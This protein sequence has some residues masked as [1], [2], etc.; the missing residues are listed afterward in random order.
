M[1][2]NFVASL[3]LLSHRFFRALHGGSQVL[4]EGFWMGLLPESVY[5]VISEKS[6]G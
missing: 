6:Y 5:D 3:Y 2:A 1:F 4:F